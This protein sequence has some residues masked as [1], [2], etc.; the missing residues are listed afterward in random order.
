M[1][2]PTAEQ[3]LEAVEIFKSYTQY[4]YGDTLHFAINGIA[5]T[6]ICEEEANGNC[7]KTHRETGRDRKE[8]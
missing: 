7:E 2:T 8:D 5:Y 6:H 3:I 4:E 1:G